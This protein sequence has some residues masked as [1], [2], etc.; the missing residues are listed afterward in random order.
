MQLAI[1]LSWPNAEYPTPSG[2]ALRDELIFLPTGYLAGITSN[3][4]IQIN[5]QEFIEQSFSSF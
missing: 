2:F 4:G 5:Q 3:T 1:D